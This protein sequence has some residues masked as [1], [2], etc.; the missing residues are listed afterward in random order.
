MLGRFIKIDGVQFPNPVTGT[1]A[2]AL[3]PQENVYLTEDG[4]QA[5]NIV[6]LDRFSF[7][8]QFNCSSMQR[9]KVEAVAKAPSCIVEIDGQVYEGRLRLSGAITMIANSERVEGTQG[10][11]VVPVKFEGF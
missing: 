11:W 6:R 7:D 3:N 4:S 10:L 8:A 5:S 9:G 2:P 1:F